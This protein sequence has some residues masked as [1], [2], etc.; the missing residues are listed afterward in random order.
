MPEAKLRRLNRAAGFPDPGPVER[1]LSERFI[2]VAESLAA[3]EALF[4]EE[5]VF[6]L[7]RVMGSAMARVADAMVSAFLVNIEPATRGEDPVALLARANSEAAALLPGVTPALDVLLRQH[8]IAARRTILGYEDFS[9]FETQQLCV[10]FV[11]LVGSTAL[12]SAWRRATLA[13]Y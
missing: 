8:L 2:E 3:A 12:P 7:L 6:Q 10:G 9:G 11:D 5:V 4:G 1:V 13:P